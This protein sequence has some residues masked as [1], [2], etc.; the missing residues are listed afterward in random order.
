MTPSTSQ[1]IIKPSRDEYDGLSQVTVEATP[2]ETRTVNPSTSS[3]TVTPSGSNI[4]FSKITVNPYRLQSKSVTPRT[5]AQT[6][7]PDSGYNG[8]SSVSVGAVSLQSKTANITTGYLE[9]LPDSGYNGLNRVSV[10]YGLS[11]NTRATIQSPSNI[12]LS[13]NFVRNSDFESYANISFGSGVNL[14]TDLIAVGILLSTQGGIQDSFG[15]FWLPTIIS[16]GEFTGGGVSFISGGSLDSVRKDTASN[17]TI[18]IYKGMSQTGSYI[19]GLTVDV[20]KPQQ[21]N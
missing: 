1:Q 17:N 10:T 9:I 21:S 7:S 11:Y 4:G 5:S 2:L 19:M 8:L 15:G 13:Y 3:Q 20:F 6:V 12:I 14:Q 18:K 16:G